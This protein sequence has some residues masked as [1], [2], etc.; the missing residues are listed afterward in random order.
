MPNSPKDLPTLAVTGTPV[1]LIAFVSNGVVP[2]N[3]FS[4]Q[5]WGLSVSVQNDPNSTGILYVGD[6]T[7]STTKYSRALAPGD[8]YTVTGSAVD[9]SKVWVVSESTSTAH[10]SWN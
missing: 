2:S 8:F 7:V 9:P 4:H 6:N 3:G 5:R 1:P 10:P